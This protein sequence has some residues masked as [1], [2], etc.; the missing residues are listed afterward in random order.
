MNV[1]SFLKEENILEDL[2]AVNKE[3]AIRELVEALRK[4]GQVGEGDVP[5]L[6]RALLRR[7]E[8]GSTGVGRGIGVPHTKHGRVTRL[9]GAF[10]RSRQGIEWKALD[11]DPVHGIF[12]ILS[13]QEAPRDHLAALEGISVLIRDESFCRKIREAPGRKDLVEL[14]RQASQNAEHG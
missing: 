7:E 10:G 12:L 4:I 1:L 5:D 8:L 11:G 2:K 13:P 14:L 9:V 6:V 3:A